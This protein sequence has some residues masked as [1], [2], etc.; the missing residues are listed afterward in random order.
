MV[1]KEFSLA[2]IPPSI[3]LATDL[4]N[5]QFYSEF[6]CSEKDDSLLLRLHE[7]ASKNRLKE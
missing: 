7:K 1:K 5:L 2:G 6:F 3:K 4:P